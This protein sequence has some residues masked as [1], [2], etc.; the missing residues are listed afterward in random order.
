MLSRAEAVCG[1]EA[2]RLR[3]QRISVLLL[4]LCLPARK[5]RGCSLLVR[6]VKL[7]DARLHHLRR[8]ARRGL[9]VRI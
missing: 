3:P 5:V 4:S 1:L 7:E 8:E 9:D 6:G 2:V